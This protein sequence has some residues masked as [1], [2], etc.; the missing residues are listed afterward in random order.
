MG[1]TYY[2]AESESGD[3]VDDPSEDM[4]FMLIDD[5]NDSDNTFVVIQP[6]EDDPAWFTS[7]AVLDEGGYEIVRRDTNRREH[8]VLTETSIDRIAL[9]L[10]VWMAAR[11][12]PRRPTGQTS[13]I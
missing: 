1:A 9:D 6:D 11:A 10:T 2:R 13:Q 12:F 3:H 5:L 7:V 8:D 4:L